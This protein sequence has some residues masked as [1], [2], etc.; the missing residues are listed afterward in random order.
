MP[1][2]NWQDEVQNGTG[3]TAICGLAVQFMAEKGFET[4]CDCGGNPDGV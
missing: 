1:A 2:W 4:T 3:E